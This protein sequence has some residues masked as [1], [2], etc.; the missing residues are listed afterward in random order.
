MFSFSQMKPSL[1]RLILTLKTLLNVGMMQS[2]QKFRLPFLLM[3]AIG[4]IGAFYFGDQ[5][6][7]IVLG[8][9][10]RHTNGLI[11][12]PPVNCAIRKIEARGFEI[13]TGRRSPPLII[14]V[15][16]KP[17]VKLSEL[18]RRGEAYYKTSFAEGVGSGGDEYSIFAVRQAGDK[19]I[20]MRRQKQSEFGHPGF[21]MEWA[22]FLT[23]RV[24]E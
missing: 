18:K 9:E 8:D 24:A 6:Q 19:W 10:V 14:M 16:S 11:V 4:A 5:P 13:C 20:V 17:D 7:D 23:A 12:K 1:I 2:F 15:G 22:V 21:D 3:V